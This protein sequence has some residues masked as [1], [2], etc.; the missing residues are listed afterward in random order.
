[1]EKKFTVEVV[2]QVNY[3]KLSF[4]YK[5]IDAL[6]AKVL[7]ACKVQFKYVPVKVGQERGTF[8]PEWLN[9]VLNQGFTIVVGKVDLPAIPRVGDTVGN[10]IDSSDFM[11]LL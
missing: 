3:G 5:P 10:G 4:T 6:G 1:M 2:P 7:S 11:A 9:F 8:A